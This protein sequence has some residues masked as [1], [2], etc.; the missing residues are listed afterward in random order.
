MDD[1]CDKIKSSLNLIDT[2]GNRR[3]YSARQ[4]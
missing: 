4:L 1:L 3:L 2:V